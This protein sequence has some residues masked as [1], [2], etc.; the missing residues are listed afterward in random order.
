MCAA[1]N[2]SPGSVRYAPPRRILRE[3]APP[4]SEDAPGSNFPQRLNTLRGIP[5]EL[6][7]IFHGSC[8]SRRNPSCVVGLH[9]ARALRTNNNLP[10][11]SY[12]TTSGNKCSGRVQY[13]NNGCKAV[14]NLQPGSESF[15]DFRSLPLFLPLNPVC[16]SRVPRWIGTASVTVH[17]IARPYSQVIQSYLVLKIPPTLRRRWTSIPPS[18]KH[19]QQQSIVSLISTKVS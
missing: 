10:L 17:A 2:E 16:L 15:R 12:R 7:V 18:R 4:D 5:K 11:Q 3:C 14:D 8:C 13:T 19:D 6:D 9:G 1:R